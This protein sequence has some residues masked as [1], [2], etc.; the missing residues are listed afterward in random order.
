MAGKRKR[1][2]RTGLICL[3]RCRGSAARKLGVKSPS[4]E[5]RFVIALHSPERLIETGLRI[6]PPEKMAAMLAC[7][8]QPDTFSGPVSE[9]EL[10]NPGVFLRF[11]EG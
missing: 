5:H 7:Q 4:P 11:S 10:R 9:R 3:D 1:V 2:H 6:C 8:L